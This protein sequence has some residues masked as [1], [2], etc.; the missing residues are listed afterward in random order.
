MNRD[1]WF[2]SSPYRR[3]PRGLE[4]AARLAAANTGLLMKHGIE[5]F[6]PIA[7]SHFIAAV[8]GIDP[9]DNVFWCRQNEPYI[10]KACG[11]I[12]LKL[13]TWENSDGIAWERSQFERQKKPEIFM[14]PGVIPKP[15]V[16]VYA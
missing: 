1:F 4:E 16:S 12:I 11:L 2:L 6:S 8:C 5:T 3:F 14:D 9:T 10:H 13:P 15:L 7:H